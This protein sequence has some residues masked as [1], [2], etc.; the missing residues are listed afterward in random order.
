MRTRRLLL[1]LPIVV[2]AAAIGAARAHADSGLDA[3]TDAATADAADA[4]DGGDSGLDDTPTGCG[5]SAP[6]NGL[7]SLGAGCC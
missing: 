4:A 1:T 5:A 7:S 3:A 2:T 6:Q